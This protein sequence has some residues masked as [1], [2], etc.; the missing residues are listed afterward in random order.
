[1][2][3]LAVGCGGDDAG[4]TGTPTQA[5]TAATSSQANLVATTSIPDVDGYE[6]SVAE[7]VAAPAGLDIATSLYRKK[8]TTEVAGRVEVRVYKDEASAKGDYAPQA[9]GWKNPPPGLLGANVTNIDSAPLA[10]FADATAYRAQA[11]DSQG[12]RVYT[13]VYRVGRVIVVQHVLSKSDPEAAVVRDAISA[14]ARAKV[15]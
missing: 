5:T 8:G 12:L 11:A 13:D 1:M 9:L 6:R 15:N 2:T 10:N 7:K 4:P 14:A 3:S